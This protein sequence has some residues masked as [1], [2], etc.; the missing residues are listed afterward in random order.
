MCR[1]MAYMGSPIIIDKLLYQPKNSLVNQSINA[2]EIEEPLNGDGFGIGWYVADV[3]YEPVTFVSI[4][5][6]WSNRNLRNLAPKIRTECFIAHVRAASVGEVSESNCHPF[7]YKNLLM[8][9]NGGV[10]NFSLIKRQIR[11]PLS[12]EFYNWIKGQTDSEHIFAL[13]LHYLY[14]E[15]SAATP[16]SVI[17]AFER[18]FEHLNRLM[19]QYGIHE[20]AYLNMVV[21]NGLFVVGT[22]YVSDPKETA[23]TLYHSEATHYAVE[24]GVSQMTNTSEG[25]KA[26]LVV[27]EKLSDDKDWTLIP[28]NH[29]VIVDHA[30]N[31]ETRPIN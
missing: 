7:Q 15:T 9:H 11:E 22:R 24:N 31:V 12:D 18:T 23:L 17:N 29:F 4:N 16:E 20:A 1:L 3:N 21:T 19:N 30:L 28:A 5:P 10:E 2:K 13:L 25:N 27:S 14:K 8:M 26:V 6:A